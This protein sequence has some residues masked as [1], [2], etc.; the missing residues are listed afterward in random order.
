MYEKNDVNAAKKQLLDDLD[1]AITDQLWSDMLDPD[2]EL[3]R[4]M[5]KAKPIE[6]GKKEEIAAQP[7]ITLKTLIVGTIFVMLISS[8]TSL[9][10]VSTFY[11]SVMR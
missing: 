9:A 4:I 2:S 10:V 8:V 5:S 1:F 3:G 6:K 7:K 11:A